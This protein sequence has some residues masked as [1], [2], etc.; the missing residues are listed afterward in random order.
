MIPNFGVV[1]WGVREKKRKKKQ[2]LLFLFTDSGEKGFKWEEEGMLFH[3]SMPFFF[4][5]SSLGMEDLEK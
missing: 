2:I 1:R 4:V 5:V 3:C